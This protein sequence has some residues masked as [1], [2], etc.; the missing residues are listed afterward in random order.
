MPIYIFMSIV[1][2]KRKSVPLIFLQLQT[3]LNLLSCPHIQIHLRSKV[4]LPNCPPQPLKSQTSKIITNLSYSTQ[5]IYVL[6]KPTGLHI[7][8]SNVVCD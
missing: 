7:L 6:I 3:V 5:Q 8:D 2:G 1:I 4:V